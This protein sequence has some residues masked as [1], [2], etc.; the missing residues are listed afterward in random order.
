MCFGEE[1]FRGGDVSGS[2]CFGERM[3]VCVRQRER[4]RE[5]MREREKK[6][7]VPGKDWNLGE[8]ADWREF[9]QKSDVKLCRNEKLP[10]F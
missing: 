4:E 9:R 3:C 6:V 5:H 8:K 2:R 1:M 10:F 7:G